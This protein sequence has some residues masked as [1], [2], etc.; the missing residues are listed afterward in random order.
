MTASHVR[1]RPARE[2]DIEQMSSL[3][4]DLFSIEGDFTPEPPRQ[5]RAL[6]LLMER[7]GA[8]LLVAEL[9]DKVVGMCSVQTTVSTAEGGLVGT[10]EDVVVDSAWRGRGI[11]T[12]LLRAAERWAWARDLKRLQLLADMDNISAL[13]FYRRWHWR[14]SRLVARQKFPD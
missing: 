10:V 11:G 4:G 14:E 1:V 6:R 2:G 3:L 13:G 7:D 9:D 12:E 5:R 8:V